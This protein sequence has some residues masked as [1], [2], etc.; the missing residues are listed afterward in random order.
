MTSLGQKP[1]LL[2]IVILGNSNAW[3]VSI[4]YLRTT[5]TAPPVL[6]NIFQQETVTVDNMQ[7]PPDVP[8]VAEVMEVY[9]ASPEPKDVPLCITK[10]DFYGIYHSFPH[11]L[12]HAEHW[13]SSATRQTST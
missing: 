2:S 13:N 9:C 12:Y 11:N 5:G 1:S 8:E 10:K 6:L 4:A 7:I 3:R